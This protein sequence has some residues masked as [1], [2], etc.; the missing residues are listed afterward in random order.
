MPSPVTT[1]PLG[2]ADCR[3][4]GLVPKTPPAGSWAPQ[5][6][7][8]VGGMEQGRKRGVESSIAVLSS[9]G[10][11]TVRPGGQGLCLA[12]RRSPPH[13]CQE[14]VL[15]LLRRHAQFVFR[16]AQPRF[17]RNSRPGGECVAILSIPPA[18]H[19][20]QGSP[21]PQSTPQS[22]GRLNTCPAELSLSVCP[23]S[24]RQ[25]VGPTD[26]CAPRA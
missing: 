12:Q 8:R 18:L 9:T 20:P 23:F 25:E 13:L 22:V 1:P 14:T 24:L 5:L 6:S 19:P 26:L 11:P 3:D 10:Q 16:R 2:I 4:P 15:S 21:T 7:K 17:P